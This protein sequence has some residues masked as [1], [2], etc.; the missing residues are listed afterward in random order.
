[1]KMRSVCP[2]IN[3]KFLDELQTLEKKLYVRHLCS[4][5]RVNEWVFPARTYALLEEAMFSFSGPETVCS[6]ERED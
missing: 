6:F 2:T 4:N 5:S 1:M 3:E